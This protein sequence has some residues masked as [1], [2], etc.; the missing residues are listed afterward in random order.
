MLSSCITVLWRK[1]YDIA[2]LTK[3]LITSLKVSLYTHISLFLFALKTFVF[4]QIV[5]P[6]GI[7]NFDSSLLSTQDEFEFLETKYLLFFK[8]YSIKVN[9]YLTFINRYW[10]VFMVCILV[11][12]NIGR[13][14][15]DFKLDFWHFDLLP[16][17]SKLW[18]ILH[19]KMFSLGSRE[20]CAASLFSVW[21]NCAD[22]QLLSLNQ[23]RGKLGTKW[24]QK[25]WNVH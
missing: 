4:T 20:A 15:S 25:Y 22:W 13:K 7:F 12:S 11:M 3:Q 8:K 24:H 21:P 5:R 17:L 6:M 18:Q 10:S 9:T 2:L 23:P 1:R 16:S 19:F 14:E